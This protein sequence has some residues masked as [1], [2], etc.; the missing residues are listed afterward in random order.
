[1]Q[2]SAA[3]YSFVYDWYQN[4]GHDIINRAV[5]D[6]MIDDIFQQHPYKAPQ[7]DADCYDDDTA[8]H[9]NLI[10]QYTGLCRF[11]VTVF[12]IMHNKF[13]SFFQNTYE[14]EPEW[15]PY[16]IQVC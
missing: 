12:F 5:F 15:L 6:F 13:S 3:V 10:I 16:H 4:D 2:C 7:E 1:M 8:E 14:R 11:A 9:V